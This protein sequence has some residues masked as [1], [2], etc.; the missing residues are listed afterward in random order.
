[1]LKRLITEHVRE[2]QSRFAERLL[3]DWV[4]ELPNFQQVVPKEMVS[5][6]PQ[7]LSLGEGRRRA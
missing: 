3:I 6:L 4:R 2:T 1:V 7:P 5:R